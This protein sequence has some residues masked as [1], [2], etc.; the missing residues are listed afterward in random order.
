MIITQDDVRRCELASIADSLL[1]LTALHE[2]HPNW[3]ALGEEVDSG[4]ILLL[5]RGMY[6]NRAM[7]VG[8]DGPVDDG[9][10]SRVEELSAQMA[11]PPAFEL[12][13]LVDSSLLEE[14][15]RRC[16]RVTGFRTILLR[17]LGP[18]EPMPSATGE[19]EVDIELVTDEVALAEWQ[20]NARTGFEL[21]DQDAQEVS[22]RFSAA[23]YRTDGEHLFLARIDGAVAGGGSLT[24]RDGL[25]TLGGMATTPAFRRRGVQTALVGHRL[26]HAAELGCDLAR[27]GAD[28]GTISERNLQRSGFDIAYTQL[29][30][31]GPEPADVGGS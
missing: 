22:D 26:R 29:F 2:T 25:A 16:Y 15:G 17:E 31:S 23:R 5:G 7:A 4:V 30:M 14:L 21:H 8:L 13:P 10:V 11:V 28:P 6:V 20:A 3:Q 9:L 24:I 27:V 1:L 12:S 19:G 18:G